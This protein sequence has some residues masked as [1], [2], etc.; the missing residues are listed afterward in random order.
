MT[1]A[2]VRA[3]PSKERGD[4]RELDP[5]GGWG[6]SQRY[7]GKPLHLGT[8]DLGLGARERPAGGG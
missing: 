4:E 1:A 6:N 8:E 5:K 3:V 2:I 7:S